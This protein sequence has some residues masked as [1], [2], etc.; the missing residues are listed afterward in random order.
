MPQRSDSLRPEGL[1]KGRRRVLTIEGRDLPVACVRMPGRSGP[2]W[3]GED[4]QMQPAGTLLR[5]VAVEAACGRCGME[6]LFMKNPADDPASGTRAGS[7]C[8]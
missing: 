2:V 8:E 5:R 3:K 4:L 6:R 7:R 1:G